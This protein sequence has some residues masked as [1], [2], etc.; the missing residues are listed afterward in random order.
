MYAFRFLAV[1]HLQSTLKIL[2]SLQTLI[3]AFVIDQFISSFSKY[4]IPYVKFI[5]V[6]WFIGSYI[7]YWCVALSIFHIE[8]M[9]ST[10]N[11]STTMPHKR[12][13][14][15]WNCTYLLPRTRLTYTVRHIT[16]SRLFKFDPRSNIHVRHHMKTRT[17][18]IA[19]LV[20][21]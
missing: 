8:W 10:L 6:T 20:L 21:I 11:A 16:V 2:S 5:S 19:L 12:I 18:F 9:G 17:D 4:Q 14:M 15:I 13:H 3:S 1:L 7:L